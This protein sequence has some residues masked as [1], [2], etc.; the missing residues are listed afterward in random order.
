MVHMPLEPQLARGVLAALEGGCAAHMLTVSAMLTIDRL[1]H[2]EKPPKDR[3]DDEHARIDQ[4]RVLL[5]CFP[6][7]HAV[8]SHLE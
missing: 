3:T 1:F 7:S 4:K 8:L 2:P 5:V 6:L